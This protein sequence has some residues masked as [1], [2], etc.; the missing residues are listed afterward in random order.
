MARAYRSALDSSSGDES[1]LE[2]FAPYLPS[3]ESAASFI[4]TP[5]FD[6]KEKIGV[7]LFQMPVGEIN[8]LMGQRAGLGESGETYLVGADRMMRSQSRFA[9]ESTLLTRK[10]TPSG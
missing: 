10:S 2:D 4:A 8:A 6:G 7:L 3:Y 1:K 5:V 9:E